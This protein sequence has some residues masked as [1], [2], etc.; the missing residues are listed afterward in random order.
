MRISAIRTSQF[1]KTIFLASLTASDLLKKFKIDFFNA[2]TERGYQRIVVPSRIKNAEDY[3]ISGDGVFP[4]SV[5][6]NSRKKIKFLKKGTTSGIDFGY[7]TFTSNLWVLD[8]QHRILAIKQAISNAD[9]PRRSEINN[10]MIPVSIMQVD[11]P[12][13]M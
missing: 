3:L 5:L 1:N 12:S 4:Q 6:L 13:E 2:R 8:G 7:L 9:E 11:K 10:M